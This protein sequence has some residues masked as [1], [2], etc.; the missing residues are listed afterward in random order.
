VEVS[1]ND[2]IAQ[3]QAISHATSGVK[4][5]A[6]WHTWL[7][8]REVGAA[9]AVHLVG[10]NGEF[11]RTYYSDFVT[12]SGLF[13]RLG[14]G[15]VRTYFAL[16]ALRR[17]RKYPGRAKLVGIGDVGSVIGALRFPAKAYPPTALACLDTF[18][19]FERVRH[20]IGAGLACYAAFG[21]P[22]SPF[23]DRRWIQSVAATQRAWKEGPRHHVEA[24]RRLWPRLLDTPF[25]ADVTGGRTRA[26]SPFAALSQ[27]AEVRDLLME[28]KGLDA[29][30]DRREREAGLADPRG[31]HAAL[32]SLLLTL[33]FAAMNARE[34]ESAADAR[35]AGAMA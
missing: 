32:V 35:R 28:S 10:S 19:A 16:R 20:F 24:M 23:L 14:R 11:A 1:P 7:Y 6:D 2:Y 21:K 26:Y 27:R 4:T 34:A 13:R 31:D 29:F 22:R 9:D 3:G 25:N 12:R 30:L 15:A 5:A 17:W 8:A 33:H 18:Y